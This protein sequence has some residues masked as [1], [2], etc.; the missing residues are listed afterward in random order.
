MV[1]SVFATLEVLFRPEEE[2]EGNPVEVTDGDVS[3]GGALVGGIEGL[4]DVDWERPHLG[5]SRTFLLIGHQLA[6]QVKV[7]FSCTVVS[8]VVGPH[9]REDL[10]NWSGGIARSIA[11]W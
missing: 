2:K 11:S 10:A 3:W 5:R 7:Y 1:I 6:S 4:D 8:G 9:R